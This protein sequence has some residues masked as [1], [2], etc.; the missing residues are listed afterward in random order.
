MDV[1][2]LD[3]VVIATRDL[4]G[5]AGQ[6]ADLLGLSFSD[7]V[8]P[9]TET[10]AGEQALRMLVSAAG[11]ELI[12]PE[13]DGNE[14]ARF[15]EEHGP[16]L[17]AL[18]LRVADLDAAEAELAAKGVEPVGAFEAKDFRESFYH[19]RNFGGALLILAEYDAPHPAATAMTAGADPDTD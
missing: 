7:T 5:T 19:P 9:T 11:V 16:G 4:E 6:F 2:G 18:S 3:R 15:V 13:G 1:L 14:V 17:Y 12:S 10:D 8:R